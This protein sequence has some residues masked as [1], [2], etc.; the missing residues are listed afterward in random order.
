[1]SRALRGLYGSWMDEMM[2][3][4]LVKAHENGTL[5]EYLRN[6]EDGKKTTEN[7]LYHTVTVEENI[8]PKENN[9]ERDNF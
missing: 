2:I 9:G 5:A 1:M 3:E 6:W 8:L 4:T 7:I